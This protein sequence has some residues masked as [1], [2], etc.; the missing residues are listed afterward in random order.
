M[1]S[2]SSFLGVKRLIGTLKL[3]KYIN[4]SSKYL[5]S[6]KYSLIL[7]YIGDSWIFI[8]EGRTLTFILDGKRKDFSGSGSKDNRDLS[9]GKY[10]SVSEKAWYDCSK[11]DLL[12]IINAKDVKIQFRGERTFFDVEFG[13]FRESLKDFEN[14]YLKD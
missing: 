9:Y 11:D 12:Q 1:E 6:N 8:P 2:N 13:N 14:K 3:Q 7:E 4:N 5:F 10:S